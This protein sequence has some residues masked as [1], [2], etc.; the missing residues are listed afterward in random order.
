MD[1]EFTAVRVTLFTTNFNPIVSLVVLIGL[2]VSLRRVV[3]FKP[4]LIGS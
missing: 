2:A 4:T 3:V 1:F